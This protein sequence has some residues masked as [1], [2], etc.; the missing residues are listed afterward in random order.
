MS[1]LL[2]LALAVAAC[3]GGE[4]ASSSSTTGSAETTSTTDSTTAT[5]TTQP[6]S[7]TSA[8]TDA[9]LPGEPFDLFIDEGDS[10]GVA[11]VAY[12]DMLNVRSKPGTE[13][14]IVAKV[15]PTAVG[16]IATGQE[17][18]LPGSIWYEV[19]VEGTTGWVNSSFVGFVGGVDDSTAEF[20]SE[21]ERPSAPTME[22]L[23]QIVADLVASVDP[24][25]RIVQSVESSV[26]DLGEVTYDVIGLGDDSL[27]GYRL[28]IFG[29]QEGSPDFLLTSIERTVF[30]S[31]GLAGELCV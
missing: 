30:C 22:Q 18:L 16:L 23:G 1:T 21:F 6:S 19:T 24:P 10:L 26:G 5:T 12:D 9:G 13:Y 20:L 8:T 27:A 3:G 15:G 17:R 7:S 2:V 28:H 29:V 4:S 25:S 31:R 11:G 14:P